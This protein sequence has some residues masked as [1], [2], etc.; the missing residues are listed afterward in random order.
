MNSFRRALAEQ[1]FNKIDADHSGELTIDDLRGVYNATQHPE[2][3]AGR[4]TEDAVLLEFLKTFELMYDFHVSYQ[5][6]SL[7]C[8]I[9]LIE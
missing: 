7:F 3:K 1:A 8:M 4:K 9:L 2:V 6:N 5:F